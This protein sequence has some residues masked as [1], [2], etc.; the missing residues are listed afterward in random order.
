MQFAFTTVIQASFSLFPACR[1]TGL[2]FSVSA[3]TGINNCMDINCYRKNNKFPITVF[4][5]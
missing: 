3:V 1:Q 4:V 5:F 2:R